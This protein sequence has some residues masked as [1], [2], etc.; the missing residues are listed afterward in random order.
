MIVITNPIPIVY[1]IDTIH[2]LFEN[3]LELLHIRK[4]NFSE[5]E[6]KLFLSKI[7]MEFRSKLVL[8]QHHHLAED[9]GISRIHFTEKDRIQWNKT[10]DKFQKPVRSIS[11]SVHT[12]NDFNSLHTIFEYSFLSPVYQSISKPDY[13]GEINLLET[14]KQ[15]TNF[16]TNLIALG[17]ITAE[18]ISQTLEK[19]FNDIALLGT[20]WNSS[21]PIKNFKLC[22][23]IV[24][25]F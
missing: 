15:R 5:E 16:N 6:M 11:T 18:N 21:N 24:L 22:Q 12:M 23:Q 13:V 3:G 14:L 17:G 4:P 2:S 8:H 19:G 7:E 10:S 25:L 9:F 20:I 1:E